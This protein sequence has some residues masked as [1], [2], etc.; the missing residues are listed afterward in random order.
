MHSF[1]GV[2]DG[3]GVGRGGRTLRMEVVPGWM[4]D[5]RNGG[6]HLTIEIASVISSAALK[7]A[8]TLS[9]GRLRGSALRREA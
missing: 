4:S 3:G 1:A 2:D 8:L 5:G 7:Q 9:A 6:Y